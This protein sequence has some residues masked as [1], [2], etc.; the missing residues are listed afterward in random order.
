LGTLAFILS[1]YTYTKIPLSLFEIKK[2]IKE[3]IVV[4]EIHCHLLYW[5]TKLTH[6]T[7]IPKK[8][9]KNKELL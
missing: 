7:I 3:E 5:V 2:E 6:K 4:Y 9:N 1:F 8:I